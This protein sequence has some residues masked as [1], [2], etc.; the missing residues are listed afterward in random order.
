MKKKSSKKQ[1]LTFHSLIVAL[2][3]W[4]TAVRALLFSL[5]AAAVF[6]VAL[7]E[8]TTATAIDYEILVLIYV[9]GSFLL[10]DFGYVMIARAY[11]LRRAVDISMLLAADVILALLYIA[12]K[13][14]VTSDLNARTDPLLFVIFVPLVILSLRMLLGILFGKLSR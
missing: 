5:L 12:P 1:T 2:S 10:L 9:L 8:T 6:V 11:R 14:V 13:V 7:S 4:G 3:F